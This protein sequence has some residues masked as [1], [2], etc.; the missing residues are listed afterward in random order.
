MFWFRKK[1]KSE[2]TIENKETTVKSVNDNRVLLTR[3]IIDQDE[4]A[5]V[6][7]ITSSIAANDK[8]YSKFEIKS[9]QEIDVEKEEAIAIV[10][11]VL[12][13]DKPLSKFRCVSINEINEGEQIC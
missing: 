6:S 8:L 4:K 13:N 7:L 1:K 9:I 10:S 11:A 12:A 2:P 3:D 5:L